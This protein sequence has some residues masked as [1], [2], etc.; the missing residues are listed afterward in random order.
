MTRPPDPDQTRE[1]RTH[2]PP[3]RPSP[4][5]SLPPVPEAP[6]WQTVNRE[7]PPIPTPPP[8]PP[9]PQPAPVASRQA[10]GSVPRR[11]ALRPSPTAPPANP[12]PQEAPAPNPTG[13]PPKKSVRKPSRRRLLIRLGVGLVVVEAIVLG[14]VLSR[15][16][17]SDTPVLDIAKAQRGVEQ[18]LTDPVDGYGAKSVTGVVCNNGKNPTVRKDSGFECDA[19]VDGTQR[20]VAVVFQ[21]D[22]GT[23]A[24]DRPR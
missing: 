18:V 2:P 12:I 23:Y 3:R 20:R 17:A 10:R 1:I 9:E 21:D 16:R 14:V 22:A 24:V 15:L 8:R 13:R 4:K 6:W 11:Q 5:T 7:V 19:V